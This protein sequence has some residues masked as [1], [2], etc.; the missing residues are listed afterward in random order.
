MRTRSSSNLPAESSPN[1]ISSNPK[2]RNRRHSKQPFII[3]E[4]PIDT[5]A[6]QRTMAELLRASTE[7]YE[8]A[9]VAWDRYKDLLHAFPHHGFMELHQLDTFSNGLNPADQDSLNSAAG[10]NLLE[11]SILKQFQL[12]P[13][14]ASVKVVEEIC[15]T[16]GGAHL[17]YQ[18]LIIGGNTF[19]E[20]RDNVQGYV[21]AAAV[22]YNQGN[23]DYRPPDPGKFL[24]PCGFSELN[25]KV[26]AN[27]GASINLMPLSVWIK[28]GL[29]ELISTRMTLELAN[30]EICTPTRIARDVFIMVGKFTFLADFVIVYY[31]SDLRVPLILGRPFLQTSRAFIDVHGEEMILRD[32]DERL[33]LNMRH[34][35]SSYYNQ[36]QKESIN[37]I[38]IYDDSINS[39]SGSTTYTS[40]NH[41]LEDFADELALIKFPSKY[42]DD[43]PFDIESDL[44]EIEYLLNHDPINEM[45]FILNDLIDQNNLADLNDN[46]VD[47]MPEMFTDE[48]AL[49][50]SSPLL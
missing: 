6:D 43:L 36:P 5:M 48:H 1:L 49:D 24:I 50:Y 10:G 30:R 21:A 31:E 11:R 14:P 41:L 25:C 28:L 13:P 46:L 37:M 15:V 8:E 4:S 26:L 44:K 45:D 38:N 39:L 17:Y 35:T 40:P 34:D 12:A 3:E 22:N 47:T 9:I 23:F 33:T 20:R 18:C 7:R 42:D 16:C 29:P 32:G 2:R 27:L 19:P